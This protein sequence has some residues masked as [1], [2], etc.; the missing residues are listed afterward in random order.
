MEMEFLEKKD[1]VLL[2]RIE[3]RF[4]A[5]HQNEPTPSR[6]DIRENIAKS[7]KA[8]KDK[9]ILDSMTSKFGLSQTI[10]YAKVYKNIE[11][12]RKHERKHILIRNRLVEEEKKEEKTEKREKPEKQ[13]KLEIKEKEKKSEKVAKT[14]KE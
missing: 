11:A 5:I 9:V 2:D 7:L 8:S 1:N 12:A 3:I 6:D 10:G 4:R 13:E 14:E